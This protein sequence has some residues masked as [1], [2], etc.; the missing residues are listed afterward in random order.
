MVAYALAA[1]AALLVVG[2]WTVNRFFVA[3]H[4]VGLRLG[5]RGM[6][7]EDYAAVANVAGFVPL[8]LLLVLGW[9]RVWAWVWPVGLAAA[10]GG[11]ELVQAQIGR[12]PS[13]QDVALNTV[14]AVVGTVL[15]VLSLKL[16]DR[17]GRLA[18]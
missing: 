12:E 15:G 5:V 9:P 18:A 14:G 8:G 7:P 16:S 13:V 11:A 4:V 10:S 3:V 6:S 2:G 1:G 17:S